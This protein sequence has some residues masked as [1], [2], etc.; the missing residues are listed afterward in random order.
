MIQV[1]E[2][3]F[4]RGWF[5]HQ[6]HYES[7]ELYIYIRYLLQD[8]LNQ[9]FFGEHF[10]VKKQTSRPKDW[11]LKSSTPPSWT[12]V[13]YWSRKWV[14]GWF[15]WEQ[16]N[17]PKHQEAGKCWSHILASFC[18]DVVA[19]LVFSVIWW[20][21]TTRLVSFSY[22]TFVYTFVFYSIIWLQI[23]FFWNW[24]QIWVFEFATHLPIHHPDVGQKAIDVGRAFWSFLVV[25][26]NHETICSSRIRPK[27]PQDVY[28]L[29][30]RV[31]PTGKKDFS[32]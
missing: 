11:K 10:P 21:F 13:T 22:Y 32:K 8:H 17:L 4:Q 30:L 23:Y 20:E 29:P 1:D 14:F 24:L 26:F 6:L 31:L 28:T 19:N 12:W 27:N 5:N 3:I 9:V 16:K 15:F 25:C 2:H 7:Y 18:N